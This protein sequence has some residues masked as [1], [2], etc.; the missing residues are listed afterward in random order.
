[1]QE[2]DQSSGTFFIISSN[3]PGT[4]AGACPAV[5]FQGQEQRQSTL[6]VR[7]LSRIGTREE[8]IT[9][10]E[11]VCRSHV[12]PKSRRRR[13]RKVI[14]PEVAPRTLAFVRYGDANRGDP[15][16]RGT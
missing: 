6:D 8:P 13:S 14:E 9:V 5:P 15:R 10:G 7:G 11:P 3:L 12:P 1:M 16:P 4:P 2:T